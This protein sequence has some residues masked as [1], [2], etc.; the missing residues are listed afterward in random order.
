MKEKELVEFYKHLDRA[1]FIDGESKPLAGYDEALPIGYGQTISQPSL[2]LEMTRMLDPDKESR[3]LEI[4]T[5][6]GYQTALLAEFSGKVFTVERI[7]ELAKSAKRRLDALGYGNVEYKTGDGSA[8]WA[9]QAPFD[10]IIVTAGA[11]IV[12]S[13]LIE[14]L[15][16]GGRMIIPVGG[17]FVQDLLLITKDPGGRVQSRSINKVVFVEMIGKYGWSE[18]K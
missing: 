15:A 1:Y 2:V 3:V 12:P 8:G 11:G 7:P 14:Q 6:S 4:G 16:A 18:G 5:G 17:R 9:E 10:R 13:E